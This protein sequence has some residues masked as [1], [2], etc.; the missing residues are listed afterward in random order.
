MSGFTEK[1]VQE[2][3]ARRRAEHA[4]G[5]WDA[6]GNITCLHCGSSV[7]RWQVTDEENPLCDTCMGD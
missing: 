2:E 7:K 1:E 4:G 5:E 6:S 3:L